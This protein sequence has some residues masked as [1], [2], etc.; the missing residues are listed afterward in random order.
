VGDAIAEG[1]RVIEVRVTEPR[2]LFDAID[3]SP[4]REPLEPPESGNPVSPIV[5][6]S[7]PGRVPGLRCYLQTGA[8][9]ATGE[10]AREHAALRRASQVDHPGDAT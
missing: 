10:R 2:Q 4:F 3:P 8:S 6:L 7:H 9:I 5:N 1:S